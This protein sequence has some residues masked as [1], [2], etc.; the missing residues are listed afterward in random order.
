M[1]RIL[2]T[3]LVAA[4]ALAP[5]TGFAQETGEEDAVVVE[6]PE[7]LSDMTLD[8]LYDRLA[9]SD[10]GE[11]G[12]VASEIT[13]RWSSSGSDSIDLLLLR[14]RE[15]MRVSDYDKALSHFSRLVAFA[16]DFAEAWN[17]RATAYFASEDYG[18]ALADLY[19]ALRLQPRHYGALSGLAIIQESLEMEDAALASYRAALEIHPHLS[20]AKEGVERLAEKVKGQPI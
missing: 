15:A 13:E 5:L 10:E 8:T 6:T 4:F 1:S 7:Q 12:R 17:A 11:A 16:P 2:K 19:H 9:T 3:A 14:G 18:F 20:G